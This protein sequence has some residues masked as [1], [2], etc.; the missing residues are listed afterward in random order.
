M[1]SNYGGGAYDQANQMAD[2]M[3]LNERYPINTN[4]PIN[5]N[6]NDYAEMGVESQVNMT[7]GIAVTKLNGPNETPDICEPPNLAY[8]A[9][10]WKYLEQ[11][12]SI[13]AGQWRN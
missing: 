8:Y 13:G 5:Y 7:N 12:K 10:I 4:Q 3:A 2:S 1:D 9:K 6:S 11:I